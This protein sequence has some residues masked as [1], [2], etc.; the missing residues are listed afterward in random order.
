MT[1]WEI[2]ACPRCARRRLALWRCPLCGGRKRVAV[3][4]LERVD[5]ATITGGVYGSRQQAEAAIRTNR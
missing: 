1:W 3:P 4:L 5:T 2:I